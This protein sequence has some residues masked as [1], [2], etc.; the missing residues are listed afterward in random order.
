MATSPSANPTPITPPRVP[1]IDPRSGL[2][3]REWY[4]FFLSLFRTSQT[5]DYL[6]LFPQTQDASGELAQVYSDAQLAAMPALPQLDEVLK[7]IEALECLP[8]PE[9]RNA[10][11]YGSFSDTTDQSQTATNTAKAM[12]FNTTDLSFGVYIG[13]PSSRIYVDRISVYNIQFSAQ[14]LN[15]SGGAHDIWIWLRRNGTDVADSTTQIRV[16]GNNTEAVAAWNFLLKMNADDYFELMWEVTD[17]AVSLWHDAGTAVHPAI[18][19][20]LLSVT[21][22]ISNY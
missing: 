1:L 3:A 6:D 13:S 4:L 10:P 12:T 20:V 7:R 9:P 2:I 19:S 11:R 15:A 5:V 21:D 18:P 16:E 14:I 17:T 22:N 8:V